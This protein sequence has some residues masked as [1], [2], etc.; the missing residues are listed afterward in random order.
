M[1]T[2]EKVNSK[3]M[4]KGKASMYATL[5]LFSLVPMCVLS[6]IIGLFSS[7][8]S[9]KS[10]EELT[11]NYMYTTAEAEGIGLENLVAAVGKNSALSKPGLQAFAGDISLRDV[12]S[13]YCYIADADGTM[14]YHPTEE[15]IGE[16]VSN[17]VV[18]GVCADM[19]A[20]VRDET[21]TISY[22]FKG[23]QK[24]ASYYVAQDLSF[25][26][27][28][29]ADAD[30]IQA[31]VDHLEEMIM[32]VAGFGVF[33]FAI[34]VLIAAKKLVNPI[35]KVS[36]SLDSMADGN[37]RVDFRAK[38]LINEIQSLIDAGDKM[39]RALSGSVSTIK[40]NSDPLSGAV[41]DVDSKT[42][43][44]VE[45][46]SQISTTIN[47]VAD[48]S[49]E[50]AE[51]AQT[52]AERAYVLGENIDKLSE[53]VKMLKGAAEEIGAANKEATKYM[54]TVM[55]S[56]D[57]SVQ[58]VRD[59]SEKITATNEAVA[60]IAEC[61]QMIED[62]S[63]Q[64]NLLSLN[65]SI[66]A[67]R[68]GEAGRGFAVVAEEIRQLADDSAK[69]ANEIRTIVESITQL[70]SETVAAASKVAEIITSEQEY[71]GDTQSKFAILSESVDV[72]TAEISNI[73]RMTAELNQ[74]KTELT[75]ATSNLG[76]ISEELGASAEEVSA[77]CE[78][79][80][81]ACVDTQARTQE[82]RAI[83][84]SLND[85]VEFFKV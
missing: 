62:I 31:P 60:N 77:S 40:G 10:L 30:E 11:F 53:N 45:A 28:I 17:E 5:V 66:E 70:S 12:S 42:T 82:M 14:L 50:V 78:H 37:L 58:A 52:M 55:T 54:D 48:T 18:K 80:A 63:S 65:A 33:F 49:Q 41:I 29:S 47:E 32:I 20:G 76:A 56:S 19:K 16:P 44:N 84:D 4:K 73:D 27:V 1:S 35:I 39:Q 3:A 74:I 68:A 59:I 79:V 81:T 7:Y 57:E 15:K 26:L 69:S 38:S 13:S 2:K 23:E 24:Y 22:E 61:V 64:T 71:I 43:E 83:N 8:E 51:N 75:N 9:K 67:A 25:V 34:V 21:D 72:S 46:I 36:A 6:L 85:A